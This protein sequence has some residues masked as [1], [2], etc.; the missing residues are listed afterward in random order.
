MAKK[1]LNLSTEIKAD[2]PTSTGRVYPR[3]LLE[4]VASD[5]NQKITE[6]KESGTPL[7]GG[8]LDRD[9]I[10]KSPDPFFDVEEVSIEGGELRA[11]ISVTEENMGAI[12]ESLAD[13]KLVV[14]PVI[15]V[16]LDQPMDGEIKKIDGI[17]SI[18]L[19]RSDSGLIQD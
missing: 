6:M 4:K 12:K 13:G 5:F 16:P 11:H 2:V 17:K 19:A 18:T 8:W 1:R 7:R 9:N 14:R 10:G 15:Q 3:K